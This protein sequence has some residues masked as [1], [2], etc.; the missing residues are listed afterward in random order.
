LI[1]DEEGNLLAAFCT[2]KRKNSEEYT[3]TFTVEMAKQAKLWGKNQVWQ[4]YPDRMLQMRARAFAIRDQFADSLKGL[5]VR[6]EVEDYGHIQPKKTDIHGEVVK[7]N[8][9]IED[10]KSVEEFTTLIYNANSIDEL[11]EIFFDAKKALA[12]RKEDFDKIVFLKDLR[13]QELEGDT[14]GLV[15]DTIEQ[16]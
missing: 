7:P 13:K 6:E 2:V 15:Q 1:R 14:S 10:A 5:A 11:K 3:Y 8:L 12:N 9:T 16:Q 4:Q